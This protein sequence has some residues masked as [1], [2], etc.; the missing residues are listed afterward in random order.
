MPQEAQRASI[1]I[2]PLILNPLCENRVDG[3]T[4]RPNSFPRKE[5]S[6]AP[7]RVQISD[8]YNWFLYFFHPCKPE[9]FLITGVF[10]N[11]YRI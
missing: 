5:K 3:K 8:D 1:G 11:K 4:P 10:F 2:V 7:T 9:K 6:V